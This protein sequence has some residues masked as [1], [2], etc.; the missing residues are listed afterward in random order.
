MLFH[1]NLFGGCLPQ[2]YHGCICKQLAPM[3]VLNGLA[4]QSEHL[5]HLNLCPSEKAFNANLMR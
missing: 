3:I 2:L 5:H 4:G 1:S